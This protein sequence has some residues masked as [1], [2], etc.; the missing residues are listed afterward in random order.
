MSNNR[1]NF[2]KASAGTLLLMTNLDSSFAATQVQPRLPKQQLLILATNW[3]FDGSLDAYCVRAKQDGYD[4]IELWWPMDQKKQQELFKTL[5]H[6][7]LEVG[8]LCAGQQSNFDE[9]FDVFKKMIDAAATKHHQKA[10]VHQLSFRPRLFHFRA[11]RVVHPTHKR[12]VEKD[13]R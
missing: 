9:H 10:V 13:R 11:E 3:G 6:Y 7:Q 2:L 8:F 5:D 12:P 1:R 4:G